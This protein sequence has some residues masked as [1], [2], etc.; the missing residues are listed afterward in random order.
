MVERD[1][2][3]ARVEPGPR[4]DLGVRFVARFG[5][6]GSGSVV[7]C[8]L[9][10]GVRARRVRGATRERRRQTEVALGAEVQ[11]FEVTGEGVGER[12]LAED[13]PPPIVPEALE[14]DLDFIGSARQPGVRT[15][16]GAEDAGLEFGEKD[17]QSL[18]V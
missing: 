8:A 18:R 14:D 5:R 13:L 10:N 15:A 11:A 1:G 9:V 7:M 16:V 6:R 12:A 2:Q 3:V 17:A 4:V